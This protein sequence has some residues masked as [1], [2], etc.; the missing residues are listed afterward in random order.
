[1]S[2]QSKRMTFTKAVREYLGSF[3]Y[4]EIS[5]FNVVEKENGWELRPQLVLDVIWS[6]EIQHL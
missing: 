5:L 4:A 3:Y 6:E 1:M 2:A